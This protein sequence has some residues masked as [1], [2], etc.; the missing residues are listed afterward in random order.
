MLFLAG[1]YFALL[2]A[3]TRNLLF[4]VGAH[5]LGNA[6]TPLLVPAGPE[7]TLVLAAGAVALAVVWRLLARS[8]AARTPQAVE[9]G[10]NST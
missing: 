2:Y 6:T 8:K 9:A 7:P 10:A 5:A 4:A 3:L 1:L